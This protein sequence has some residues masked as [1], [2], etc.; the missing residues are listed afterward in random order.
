MHACMRLYDLHAFTKKDSTLQD[1]LINSS[2]PG[3]LS[4]ITALTGTKEEFCLRWTFFLGSP[5]PTSCSTMWFLTVCSSGEAGS[6]VGR[7]VLHFFAPTVVPSLLVERT[8]CHVDLARL[9][10]QHPFVIGQV[11]RCSGRDLQPYKHSPLWSK[12][13]C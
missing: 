10:P 6:I 8:F 9:H 7:A 1:A 3:N 13:C 2:Q 12:V 4:K 5:L 11:S